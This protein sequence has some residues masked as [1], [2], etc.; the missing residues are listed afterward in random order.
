MN[1]A[2]AIRHMYPNADSLRDFKVQDDGKGQYIAEWSIKEAQ[3][4]KEELQV[5]WIDYLKSEKLEELNVA[6]QSTILGGFTASNGHVYQ[7]DFKD[8]D[9]IAQQMLFIV[10]DLTIATIDWKTID[11]G[12]V[13]HTRDEFLQMCKDADNHK[14]SN[15]A[16]YW[17]L[18]AQLNTLTTEDEIKNIN[19]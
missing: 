7:F 19:W 12:I 17:T 3:P 9:N 5:A 14:R 13:T 8:Q 11:A 1:I 16:K 6:C 4:T 10:N 18:E 2:L 15:F